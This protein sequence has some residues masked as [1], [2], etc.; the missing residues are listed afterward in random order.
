MPRHRDTERDRPACLALMPNHCPPSREGC[1]TDQP[2]ATLHQPSGKRQDNVVETGKPLVELVRSY[3]QSAG[4]NISEEGSCLVADKLIFGAERDTRLVWVPEG[5]PAGG[6]EEVP[7]LESISEVRANYPATA[8][9]AVVAP[10]RE[11]FSRDAQQALRESRVRF[12]APIQFFDSRFR[13]EESKKAASSIADIREEAKSMLRVPQ[14]FRTDFDADDSRTR[15]NQDLFLRLKDDLS[16]NDGA[17]IRIIVG[18]AG[19]G[20]SYLFKALFADLYQ[21]FLE[22]KRGLRSLPRPIPLLPEHLRK[23][24]SL[25]TEDLIESFL[26][27][28]VADPMSSETFKWLLVEGYATWLL[29]GL[30]ELYAGDPGFFDY[31]LGLVT[32]P[33][34]MAQ[35]G[36]WCRDSLLTT[37]QAFSEFQELC[38]GDDILKIYRLEDWGERSKRQFVWLQR[39]G[40][41]PR[42]DEG[43]SAEVRAFLEALSRDEAT[44][45][46]SGLPLYCKIL[47]D[48]YRENRDF[49]RF[50]DEVGLLD[51]MIGSVKDRE[52]SKGLFDRNSFEEGGLDDWLEQ[53]AADYVEGQYAGFEKDDAEEYATYVLRNG[54]TDDEQHH[55]LTSL[56]NFPLFQEGSESGKVAFVHDLVADAVAARYYLRQLGRQTREI[57]TRLENVDVDNA[58]LLRFMARKIDEGGMDALVRELRRPTKDRSFAVA[59]TLMMLARPEND[60]LRRA[61][62][63]LEDRLLVGVKFSDRDLSRCSFRGSDLTYA[64]FE[65]CNLAESIFDGAYLNGTAFVGNC[66]LRGAKVGNCRVQSIVIGSRREDDINRIHDWFSENSGIATTGGRCPTAQQ[67]M[68]LFS[69]YVTPLGSPRRDRLD[70]K[71]LNAGKRFTG[72][73]SIEDCIRTAVGAGYLIEHGHKGT[74]SRAAGDEYAEVVE[75]VTKRRASDGIGR[76]L[77]RLCAR[78]NCLHQLE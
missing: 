13:V 3:L 1:T 26:R 68:H 47:Y 76:M 61:D 5:R 27:T 10:L 72:A 59:L 53:I 34:T 25:R 38:A 40:R 75:F 37:S 9:A 16:K 19:I 31:L 66:I 11:G 63:N 12:L 18:R 15:S 77:E 57:L 55:I 24:Q 51:H 23:T 67:F 33:G 35:V 39:E 50:S 43:D 62:I 8:R 22:A 60:V 42:P 21:G 45:V 54:L 78:P 6:Y 17:S 49:A 65:D 36:I 56:L 64:V 4:F 73:A 14:S 48:Q 2:Y 52:I 71:A 32:T 70:H 28:D 74:Y 46:I 44:E 69:K 29:D 41:L 30:D 20:K 58:P 7:L